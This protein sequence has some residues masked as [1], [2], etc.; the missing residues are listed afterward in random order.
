MLTLPLSLLLSVSSVAAGESILVVD[1][2][3][4]Y[5]TVIQDVPEPPILIEIHTVKPH[6]KFSVTHPRWNKFLKVVNESM[7]LAAE[8]IIYLHR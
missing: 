1:H 6:Q 4:D 5:Q 2:E 3:P 8:V 7:Q